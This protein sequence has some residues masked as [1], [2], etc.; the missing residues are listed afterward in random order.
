MDG[1]SQ[2]ISLRFEPIEEA[3][4]IRRL[5]IDRAER[6][7]AFTV[8]MW[9]ALPALVAR[10]VDEGTRVLLVE[11]SGGVFSAGADLDEFLAMAED[12]ALRLRN[13]EA[14]VAATATLAEA[15]FATIAVIDGAAAGA[16]LSIAAACDLRIA[17]RAARF[18]L[19][20]AR[21]GLVY[22]KPDLDRLTALIGPARVKHMLF[23]ARS[24]DAEW[25]SRAGLVEELVAEGR[26]GEVARTLAR[27][28]ATN[29]VFSIRT[30]KEMLAGDRVVQ[31]AMDAADRDRFLAA[32]DGPDFAEGI[33]A[34]REKRPPRFDRVRRS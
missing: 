30:A 33:A 23:T 8:A 20:P 2:D 25:A 3:A 29:S 5:L 21:L 9:E 16:G 22:P 12:R 24:F 26:S 31:G 18:V 10:A 1:K 14:I 4:G 27:M 34:F 17:S 7:N 19:P 13:Y 11:A 32:Y 6:K 28:I 15:P